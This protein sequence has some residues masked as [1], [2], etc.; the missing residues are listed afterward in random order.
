M[1]KY[2][3][4][5]IVLLIASTYHSC[6]DLDVEPYRELYGKNFYT[7]RIQLLAG[8]QRPYTHANAWAAP[9]GQTGSWRISELSA[10]QLAWPQK[11]RHGRDGEQWARL[12]YHSWVT[13]SHDPVLWSPWRLMYWGIGFINQ[14][15]DDF[16]EIDFAAIGISDTDRDALVGDLYAQRAWHYLRL[17]DLYGNIPWVTHVGPPLSP[18]TRPREEIFNLIEAELLRIADGMQ[19]LDRTLAGRMSKAAVYAM[20]VELYL[21][22]EEWTGTQRWDDCIIYA[23][24]LING[25]GGGLNGAPQL[26]PDIDVT[27]GNRN[28]LDSREPFFQIG[29]SRTG[30]MWLGRGDFGSYNERRIVGSRDNGNNGIVVTPNAFNAYSNRDLRKWSWFMYGIGTEGYGGYNFQGPYRD[31]NDPYG[32]GTRTNDFVLQTEE[33]TG[34]PMIFCYKP[35]RVRYTVSGTAFSHP[36]DRPPHPTAAE[37][38]ARNITITDWF[39]PEFP[40]DEAKLLIEEAMNADVVNTTRKLFY[41]DRYDAAQRLPNPPGYGE[42]Y[43]SGSY[44]NRGQY[45]ADGIVMDDYRHILSCGAENVG[46]RQW[47]YKLGY[48]NDPANYA[49]NHFVIYRLSWIV[50][51]KAEA[52]MRK[53]GNQ[54]T[55]EVVDLINSVKRRAFVNAVVPA[56]EYWDTQEAVDN[57]DRYTT[58]NFDMDEFLA[59]RGREFFM[60]GKRRMDLIRFGK[61]EFGLDDWWDSGNPGTG[62]SDGSEGSINRDIT[63]RLFGIPYNA[64]EVNPNLVQNPGYID[65]RP[66]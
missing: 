14:T 28:Y 21:N 63:R 18:H 34:T 24:K 45:A 61:F 2:S 50:F 3:V 33:F 17:M 27:F 12:H 19:I 54:P 13:Q 31:I 57:R 51:A 8:V 48:A 36:D 60:E 35:I 65:A 47:K 30:G 6:T 52:I 64:T 53:N 56:S 44:I 59:E 23:D 1:K 10:D 4:L 49:N 16:S 46:A 11:G 22:A 29:Y 55:Q 15:L 7:N 32:T 9:T 66:R 58:A 37:I 42:V 26:D 62:Y 5:I 40:G 41:I 43:I 20:L 38:R 39:S 25:E